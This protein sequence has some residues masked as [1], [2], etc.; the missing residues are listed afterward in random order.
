MSAALTVITCRIGRIARNDDLATL[1]AYIGSETF[2]SEFAA[3]PPQK[4]PS[5]FTAYRTAR[6]NCLKRKPVAAPREAKADWKKPG[7]IDRFKRLWLKHGGNTYRIA[8]DMRITEGAV[9][10]AYSR[11][12]RH[13]V[14][15]TYLTGTGKKPPRLAQQRQLASQP[16]SVARPKSES[17]RANLAAA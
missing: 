14:T 13:G 4:R 10:V 3:L 1:D 8:R 5:V 15:T 7:E 6:E 9:K 16:S 11:F 2:L 12:I 17:V